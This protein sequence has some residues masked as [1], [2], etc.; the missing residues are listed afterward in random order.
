MWNCALKRVWNSV[1][2][3]KLLFKLLDIFV[4]GSV[5]QLLW[6]CVWNV[7][8]RVCNV[9]EPCWDLIDMFCNCLIFVLKIGLRISQHMVCYY[10]LWLLLFRCTSVYLFVNC[11]D[12]LWS[13]VTV[14][15]F[16]KID[17]LFEHRRPLR[18]PRLRMIWPG[19]VCDVSVCFCVST[20]W[21]RMRTL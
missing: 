6:N 18:S 16:L 10:L 2:V 1:T 3:L 20:L 13:F 21:N 17:L 7:L 5:L 12:W 4:F 15:Y 11:C 14:C 19:K 9:F 8:K